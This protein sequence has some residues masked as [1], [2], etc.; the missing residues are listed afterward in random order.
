MLNLITKIKKEIKKEL[1]PKLK[2]FKTF[3]IKIIHKKCDY[4]GFYK[5]GTYKSPLIKLNIPTIYNACQEYNVDLYTA[6]YTT[7]LHEIAH[8]LQDYKNLFSD[9]IQAEN[10]A[11]E[12]YDYG[13]ILKI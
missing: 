7:L 11:V 1:L 12:Y 10:F 5:T 2:T 4:L 6:I 8:A 3:K 9:E 13:K